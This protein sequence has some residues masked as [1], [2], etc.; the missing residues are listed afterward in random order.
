MFDDSKRNEQFFGTGVALM[1]LWETCRR[2]LSTQQVPRKH[3][4]K[5]QQEM[6]QLQQEARELRTSLVSVST[7]Y[8]VKCRM[9]GML[10]RQTPLLFLLCLIDSSNL[11]GLIIFPAFRLIPV[12]V[13]KEPWIGPGQPSLTMCRP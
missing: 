3:R 4:R 12:T 13:C 7:M 6:D 11:I 8:L 2:Q 5:W 9:A 10:R 1:D